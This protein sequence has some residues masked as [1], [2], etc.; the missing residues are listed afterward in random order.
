LPVSRRVAVFLAFAWLAASATP[1]G[2]D[3]TADAAAPVEFVIVT[4]RPPYPVGND[5]FS[6]TTLAH[7][8]LAVSG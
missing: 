2:G 4:A 8:V 7:S 3:Q 5:A 6:T 1:V